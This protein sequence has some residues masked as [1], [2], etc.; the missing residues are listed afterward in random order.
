MASLDTIAQV[1]LLLGTV[2]Y[3]VMGLSGKSCDFIIAVVSMIVRMS[4]AITFP[5]KPVESYTMD[6]TTIL[7]QLPSSLF[8]ALSY[9]QLDGSTT[10][11][12]ACPSCNYTH[13]AVYNRVTAEAVYPEHCTNRILTKDGRITC[14][15]NLLESRQGSQRPLKPF[16]SASL[17][18]Y[19]A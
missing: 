13:K 19:L 8:E 17:Q 14:G 18:D 11:Y 1:T 16:V 4:M 12:A 3:F 15:A 9:F 10:I 5:D 6:Q 2:A 7:Q